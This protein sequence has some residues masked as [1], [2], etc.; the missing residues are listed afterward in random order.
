MTI[1]SYH[2]FVRVVL[3]I[4]LMQSFSYSKVMVQCESSLRELEAKCKKFVKISGP[5]V[6]PSAECCDIIKTLDIPRFCKYIIPIIE[7]DISMEK[8][9]YVVRTCGIPLQAGMK[10]GG[11]FVIFIS[12]IEI[13]ID[14][15]NFN[16]I[17]FF[18]VFL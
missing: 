9:V 1:L 13:V 6:Y 11:K 12:E 14:N 3:L 5:K 17:F 2:S 18:C 15:L 10:C 4:V 8:V 16:P 7:K